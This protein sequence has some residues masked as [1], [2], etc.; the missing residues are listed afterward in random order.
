MSTESTPLT[1]GRLTA[2]MMELSMRMKRADQEERI[3]TI[4][5][6]IKKILRSSPLIRTDLG[7]LE[8]RHVAEIGVEQEAIRRR[9]KR[10]PDR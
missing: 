5:A 9:V 1:L 4:Q 2:L 10:S 7:T 6:S 8:N 3:W